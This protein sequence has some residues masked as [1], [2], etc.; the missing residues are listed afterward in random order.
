MSQ[1]K[2]FIRRFNCNVTWIFYWLSRLFL[3]WV[4][5]PILFSV[6]FILGCICALF[7]AL[8]TGVASILAFLDGV[9]EHILEK[10]DKCV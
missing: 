9:K 8:G 6:F 3:E 2:L 10:L 5:W 7:F 1:I 4:L